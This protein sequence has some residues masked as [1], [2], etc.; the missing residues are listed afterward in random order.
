VRGGRQLSRAGASD[1]SLRAARFEEV[2]SLLEL[3]QR[4]IDRGCRGHYDR[5]QRQAV[6]LG[7]A[8]NLFVDAVG[9]LETI[10]AEI[11]GRPAAVAQLDAN[12]GVLRALFVDAHLQGR[13]VGHALLAA[14]ETRARA[15][16]CARLAGAMS[17]N[18][19]PFYERAGFRPRGRPS[20]L[21]NAG[22]RVPV[23]WMEKSLP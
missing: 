7:Y 11:A 22:V 10:V 6:Y 20:R 18:A 1:L 2:S 16:G 21:L 13:G 23:V 17:L 3:I 19:V 4:A 15:E 9:P 12:A 5:A 14:V 8:S